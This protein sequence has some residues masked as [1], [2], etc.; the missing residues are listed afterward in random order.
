VQKNCWWDRALE[1]LCCRRAGRAL[2]VV[3]CSRVLFFP[4]V[5]C[6]P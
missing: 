2:E 5:L 3:P 4:R 6:L 1:D